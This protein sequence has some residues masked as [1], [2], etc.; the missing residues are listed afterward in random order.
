MAIVRR[1]PLEPN[2]I[3]TLLYLIWRKKQTI[4]GVRKDNY[5]GFL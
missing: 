5:E 4:R 2:S 3:A 1:V